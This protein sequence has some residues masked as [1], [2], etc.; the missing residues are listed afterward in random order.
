MCVAPLI[1]NMRKEI[2]GYQELTILPGKEGYLQIFMPCVLIR[3]DLK[4]CPIELIFKESNRLLAKEGKE[5]YL[6]VRKNKVEIY[7]LP[8]QVIV[9]FDLH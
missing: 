4:C 2:T 7:S 5:S 9:L 8:C 6:Q 1:I 3:L